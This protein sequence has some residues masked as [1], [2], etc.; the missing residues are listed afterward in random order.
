LILDGSDLK[1]SSDAPETHA[2]LCT[3]ARR[4]PELLRWREGVGRS[5]SVGNTSQG[6]GDAFFLNW[7]RDF[8]LYFCPV[9]IAF[10]QCSDSGSERPR[11]NFG[12]PLASKLSCGGLSLVFDGGVNGIEVDRHTSTWVT[13]DGVQAVRCLGGA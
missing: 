10:N 6:S 13:G 1:R 4:T 2:P 12:K 8:R 7:V 3:R 5:V 9:F 11:A